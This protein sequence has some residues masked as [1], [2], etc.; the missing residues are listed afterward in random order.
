MLSRAAPNEHTPRHSHSIVKWDSSGKDLLGWSRDIILLQIEGTTWLWKRRD[1]WGK[2]KLIITQ[3]Y[4][5]ISTF[6]SPFSRA[7]KVSRYYYYCHCYRAPSSFL[8]I[9]H[10]PN[11][12]H[13]YLLPTVKFIVISAISVLS[14]LAL[15]LTLHGLTPRGAHIR[16]TTQLWSRKTSQTLPFPLTTIAEI[17][18]ENGAHNFRTLIKIIVP[19]LH[20]KMYHQ[21]LRYQHCTESR[22]LQLFTTRGYPTNENT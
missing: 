6:S 15:G 10:F 18:G 17:S 21:L 4:S 8:Q 13:L 3:V 5:S 9:H 7:P 16:P 11:K 22:R 2:G 20:R 14:A 19:R 1:K 12:K